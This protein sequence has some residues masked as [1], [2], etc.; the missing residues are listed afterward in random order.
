MRGHFRYTPPQPALSPPPA[1]WTPWSHGRE[2]ARRHGR[3]PKARWGASSSACSSS[4]PSIVPNAAPPRR[5]LVPRATCRR[6]PDAGLPIADASPIQPELAYW[7]VRRHPPRGPGCLGLFQFPRW[8]GPAE[9]R[10]I[11]CFSLQ[12]DVFLLHMASWAPSSWAAHY[13]RQQCSIR[14]L[15]NLMFPSSRTSCLRGGEKCYGKWAG[16]QAQAHEYCST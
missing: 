6:S 13:F 2:Q 7:V 14:R 4:K 11:V 10:C 8:A 16:H 1:V 12:Q 5:P 3:A 9:P 15:Q